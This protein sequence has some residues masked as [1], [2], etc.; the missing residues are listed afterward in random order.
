MVTTAQN[1]SL[2]RCPPDTSVDPGLK[3]K[4]LTGEWNTIYSGQ[5]IWRY[6]IPINPVTIKADTSGLYPSTGVVTCELSNTN[7]IWDLGDGTKKRGSEISHYYE[8]PGIYNIRLS[9]ARNDGEI[10]KTS[11][12][13]TVSAFNYFNDS[14]MWVDY[15]RANPSQSTSASIR[16]G[17]NHNPDSVIGQPVRM[18]ISTNNSWQSFSAVSA[19]GGYKVDL[20]VTNS[21]SIPLMSSTYEVNKYAQFQ[22]TWRFTTDSAG[23]NPV[24]SIISETNYT[25]LT[26]E[27][28]TGPQYLKFDKNEVT[29]SSSAFEANRENTYAEGFILCLSSAPGA[30]LVGAI[31]S[32]IVYYSDDTHSLSAVGLRASFN[33]SNWPDKKYYMNYNINDSILPKP[34]LNYF[35]SNYAF[36]PVGVTYNTPSKLIITSNGISES[37]KFDVSKTKFEHTDIPFYISVSDNNNN[38]IKDFPGKMRPS[39]QLKGVSLPAFSTPTTYELNTVYFATSSTDGSDNLKAK[40]TD[41]ALLT[42][43]EA[44]GSYPGV[45]RFADGTKNNVTLVGIMSTESGIISGASAPFNVYPRSGLYNT[46]KVNENYDFGGTLK[47]YILQENI[48]SNKKLVDEFLYEIFGDDKDLP[49]VPGKIIYEKIANFVSNNTDI[50]TCNITNLYS[51]AKELQFE[52]EDYNYSFPGGLRRLV[53]L[54]SIN[55]RKL[56]GCRNANDTDFDKQGIPDDLTDTVR[57]GRNRTE[58]KVSTSTYMVTAGVPIV[59]N[60]LFQ[61]RYFKVSPMVLGTS[62]YP[63]SSYNKSWGWG[64]DWP[65][66]ETFDKYYEFYKYVPN[67]TYPLTAFDQLEGVIDWD[68]TST[69]LSDSVSTLTETNSSYSEWSKQ[70]GIMDVMIENSLRQGLGVFK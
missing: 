23:L 46:L 49:T 59:V 41:N 29:P 12:V 13:V 57:Y 52:L 43:I 68:S 5:S 35:Q 14:I 50:D 44:P 48:F 24:N 45:M 19:N 27:R 66:N 15:P 63:L 10:I 40:F 33:T 28:A 69:L 60:D 42:A 6:T 8:W 37:G 9:V 31:G 21:L 67:S 11:T 70:D 56:F 64:L 51:F 58:T 38:I 3:I 16:A 54:L 53:D 32:G 34:D 47:S 26:G 17:S 61:D 4:D 36:L 55:H 20:Y 18:Y 2:N 30:A 25:T 7:L 39:V 1:I 65:E 62:I 22:K